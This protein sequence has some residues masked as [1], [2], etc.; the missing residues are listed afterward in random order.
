MKN[1]SRSPKT[2][3]VA[4][5]LLLATTLFTLP[6]RSCGVL[7]AFVAASLDHLIGT[8]GR[9][10]LAAAAGAIAFIL[11][12]PPGALARLLSRAFQAAAAR[13]SSEVVARAPAARVATSRDTSNDTWSEQ[14]ALADVRFNLNKLGYSRKE[15]DEVLL[16]MDLSRPLPEI[17]RD[18]LKTLR[19]N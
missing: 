4:A 7:G 16:E 19:V 15:Y 13:R 3:P 14:R 12:T 9:V 17:V 11:A 18:V 2:H 5:V 6:G 8:F 10:L 1:H